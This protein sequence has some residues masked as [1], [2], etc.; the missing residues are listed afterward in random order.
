VI[1]ET[2]PARP[3]APPG[4]FRPGRRWLPTLVVIGVLLATAFGGF[5]VA[6]ALPQRTARP[7]TL[8]GILTMRPLPGWA[9]S[10]RE[11]VSL[12]TFGGAEN[13]EFA[14]LT[15]GAG[16]LDL[17]VIPDVRGSPVDL[18]V[19]YRD[20]VLAHQLERLS[21]SNEIEPIVL[22]HGLEGVRFHYIGSTS[23]TGA[24]VEGSVTVVVSPSGNGAVFDGW[25]FQGQLELLEEEL[26]AMV[27]GAEVA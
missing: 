17:L 13:G 27:N 19:L 23:G 8:G 25:A 22:G 24:A 3:D 14:Q 1:G 9:V 16:A 7:L 21:V 4:V 5:V 12:P 26:S 18:A 6:R 10:R 2:T 11:P 15:R 20:G